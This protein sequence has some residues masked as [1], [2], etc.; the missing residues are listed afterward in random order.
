MCCRWTRQL[1]VGG[2]HLAAW[3]GR[4][5]TCGGG[6]EM[7]RWRRAAAAAGCRQERRCAVLLPCCSSMQVRSSCGVGGGG[8]VGVAWL[9]LGCLCARAAPAMCGWRMVVVL[10]WHCGICCDLCVAGK[11]EWCLHVASAVCGPLMCAGSLCACRACLLCVLGLLSVRWLLLFAPA[12]HA[13]GSHS[14]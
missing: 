11:W 1:A 7:W 12:S 6:E 8:G 5:I 13:V 10:A 4:Q 14:R 9:V 2:G 3:G